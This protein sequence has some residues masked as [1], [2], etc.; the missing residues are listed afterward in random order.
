MVK[1]ERLHEMLGEERRIPPQPWTYADLLRLKFWKDKKNNILHRDKNKCTSCNLEGTI[2]EWSAAKQ[3]FGYT[4]LETSTHRIPDDPEYKL[5]IDDIN[6]LHVRY[7]P[8][9]PVTLHVHH[10]YYLL[11]SLP[12]EY[13]DKVLI[14][15]CSLCHHKWH[16]ENTATVYQ[17]RDGKYFKLMLTPCDRCNGVGSL[18]Q[19]DYYMNG[20]CFKCKGARYDQLIDYCK[21]PDNNDKTNH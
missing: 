12:W 6:S 21:P 13:N 9:S 7:I 20:V 2:V 15:Y 16:Q 18:A 1:Y 5:T 10:H 14:T 17:K 19:F 3:G 8:T 11:D 4:T